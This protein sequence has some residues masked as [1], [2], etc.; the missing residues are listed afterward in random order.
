[1]VLTH[2]RRAGARA[3]NLAGGNGLNPLTV[4]A[5]QAAGLRVC[6]VGSN[7]VGDGRDCDDRGRNYGTGALFSFDPTKDITDLGTIAFRLGQQ[8]RT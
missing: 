3:T 5:V 7:G 1:M 2:K 8:M 4:Q 6:V